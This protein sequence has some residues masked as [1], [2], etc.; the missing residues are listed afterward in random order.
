MDRKGI[1]C[2]LYIAILLHFIRKIAN[3]LGLLNTGKMYW[4]E[5]LSAR[6]TYIMLCPPLDGLTPGTGKRGEKYVSRNEKVFRC[7]LSEDLA[8]SGRT[9]MTM[10]EA[11]YAWPDIYK[12]AF[13]IYFKEFRTRVAMDAA[14]I[15]LIQSKRR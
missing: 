12:N 2:G 13:D 7:L 6:N 10:E 8:S 14:K 5:D 11:A 1:Y 15:R 3:T 9:I 4:V